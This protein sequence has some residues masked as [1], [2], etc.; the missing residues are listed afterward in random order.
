MEETGKTYKLR[1]E[2]VSAIGVGSQFYNGEEPN[3][4]PADVPDEFWHVVE[5]FDTN[6]WDQYRNLKKWAETGEQLIRNVRLYVAP[7]PN[8]K[9]AE[10]AE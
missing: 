10:V 5:K 2:V 7:V 4:K 6:L 9:W 1:F 3:C 8:A